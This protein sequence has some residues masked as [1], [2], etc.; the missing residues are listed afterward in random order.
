ME[1][2]VDKA[3][4]PPSSDDVQP[5]FDIEEPHNNDVLCG[6]GVTTNKWAGNEQFRS[7]V[8]MNKVRAPRRVPDSVVS[9]QIFRLFPKRDF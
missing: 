4:S 3:T 9:L 5:M 8:G 1:S 6:R 2:V 7:F